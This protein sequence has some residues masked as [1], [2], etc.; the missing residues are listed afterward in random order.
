VCGKEIQKFSR[1]EEIAD[2]GKTNDPELEPKL[3]K[4]QNHKRVRKV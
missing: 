2:E 3:Y 4:S 1:R